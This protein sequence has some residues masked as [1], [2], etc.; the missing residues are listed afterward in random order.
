MAVKL[1]PVRQ[2]RLESIIAGSIIEAN[3]RARKYSVRLIDTRRDHKEA[4]EP[5]CTKEERNE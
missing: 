2:H 4:S 5:L 3:G 1:V